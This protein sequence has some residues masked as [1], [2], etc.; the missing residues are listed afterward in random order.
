MIFPIGEIPFPLTPMIWV[1]IKPVAVSLTA[2]FFRTGTC[3]V[4]F[5]RIFKAQ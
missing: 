1:K 4:V 5:L 3:R 2:P